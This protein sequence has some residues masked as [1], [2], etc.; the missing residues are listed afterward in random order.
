MTQEGLDNTRE[1]VV[2]AGIEELLLQQQIPHSPEAELAVIGNILLNNSLLDDAREA[3]TP[4]DFF[5]AQNR[6]AYAAICEMQGRIDPILVKEQLIR[7]DCWKYFGGLNFFTDAMYGVP[8]ISVTEYAHTV[9]G[10]SLLRRLIHAESAN[11]RA[12][13]MQEG[14]PWD[15]LEAAEQRLYSI[16]DHYDIADANAFSD[17]STLSDAR[18]ENAMRVMEARQSD[19]NHLTGLRTGFIEV[20]YYTQGL[21]RT[22][23]I[24]VAARPSMGKTSFAL[25][26]GQ[27]TAAMGNRV[28]MFSLEMSEDS[29]QD[30]L[31]C[32]S[33]RVDSIRF[34][35]GFLNRDEW[36][37]L[38]EA[39]TSFQNL[40]FK[41]NDSPGIS[42]T[43]MRRKLR[44]VISSLP[45]DA[46]GRKRIDLIIV[47]YLQLMTGSKKR[48]E[49]RQA[50]I[51]DISRELKALAK[52]F[53]CPLN[54]AV[55][56][57]ARPGAASRPPPAACR[58]ARV[59]RY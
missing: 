39:R 28:I 22:D 37:R 34:R 11:I 26:V 35:S 14:D 23:L 45:A 56:I 33:A 50:E 19:P 42:P 3:V 30:R 8:G 59:W 32:S 44:R 43:Y 40:T 17:V 9:K 25:N 49:S 47:D 46:E 1:F 6:M 27:N 29:L 10:Y 38:A 20:D 13:A 21:Q 58:P 4:D 51:S 31:L 57:V 12:A 54:S 5:V 48:Y 41:I 15:I 24:I 18:I 7:M 55:S 36:A 53:D 52:E 2:E 16:R